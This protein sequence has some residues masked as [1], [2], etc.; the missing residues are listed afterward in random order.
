VIATDSVVHLAGKMG[1]IRY[2]DRGRVHLKGIPAPVHIVELRREVSPV[3]G[4]GWSWRPLDWSKALGWRLILAV[5]VIA[6]ATAAA[7]VLLTTRGPKRNCRAER[8]NG[9]ANGDWGDVLA[10]D[11]RRQ[12]HGQPTATG[13]R[14]RVWLATAQ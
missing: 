5:C 2:V 11:A 12:A 1:G 9:P 6:A 3:Q 13:V 7:V 14:K 4:G 8:R 10:Y